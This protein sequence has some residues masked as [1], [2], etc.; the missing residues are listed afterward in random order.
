MTCCTYHYIYVSLPAPAIMIQ[1]LVLHDA[2]VKYG[3]VSAEWWTREVRKKHCDRWSG[4]GKIFYRS[5]PCIEATCPYAINDK[6]A[7]KSR[8][9]PLVEVFGYLELV[10]FGLTNQ[11]TV[12]GWIWTNESVPL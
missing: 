6:D 7:A 11:S 5:F 10:I 9:M 12:Y 4:I 1:A 8:E 2:M 3:G